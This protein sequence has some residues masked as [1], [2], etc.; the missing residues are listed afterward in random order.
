MDLEDKYKYDW[1]L[2]FYL[3]ELQ[4]QKDTEPQSFYKFCLSMEYFNFFFFLLDEGKY[5][6]AVSCVRVLGL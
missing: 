6:W 3:K 2:R 4:R 5:Q 1:R